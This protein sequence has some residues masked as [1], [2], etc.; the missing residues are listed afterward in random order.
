MTSACSKT[1]RPG[2]IRAANMGSFIRSCT[3]GRVFAGPS[4]SSVGETVIRDGRYYADLLLAESAGAGALRRRRH[5]AGVRHG[6]DL[7]E[8]W[9]G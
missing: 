6:D 7:A 9:Q 3:T 8:K 5:S 4:R 1:C 2:S